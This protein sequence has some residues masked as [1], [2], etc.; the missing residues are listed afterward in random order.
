MTLMPGQAPKR[1]M[2]GITTG[3]SSARRDQLLALA[4]GVV[5]VGASML[6]QGPMRELRTGGATPIVREPETSL[7]SLAVQFPRLT[8]GGFRGL[9]ATVLWIQAENDKND[10]KWVEL[11]TKYDIIGALQPYFVTVYVFHSWNLAYNL[12][13]QWHTNDR[14]YKWVLDGMDYLYRGEGYNPQNPDLL[15]EEG[16]LYFLKLGGS[17]ERI[18]YRKQWRNDLARMHDLFDE[19]GRHKLVDSGS[20]SDDKMLALDHVHNFALRGQ[21]HTQEMEDPSGSG[22]K[23]WGVSITDPV[24][25]K[26]RADGKPADQPM[27]FRYGLSPYYFGYAE[28][29]RCLAA[30]VPSTTGLNVIDA[31][32]AMSLRLWCRDDLYYGQQTMKELFAGESAAELTA[33]GMNEKVLEI[34][35]CYRNVQ[36][37]A[38]RAVDE[39]ERHL[40]VYNGTKGKMNNEPIHR[41]HIRETQSYQAIGKAEGQLFDA[42]VQWQV[43]G[44]KLTPGVVEKLKAALPRY[45]EA[46]GK[47]NEWLDTIYPVTPG[48]EPNPDRADFEKFVIALRGRVKGIEKMLKTPPEERPSLTFL[49]DETVEK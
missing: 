31:W 30:G 49:N 43:D 25:F 15:L 40:L 35:D 48:R 32:P 23:G 39:F 22:R 34:R 4:A 6:L 26:D 44:R 21:F 46:I 13:A 16:H 7:Q 2:A 36:M 42:L 5:L 37:I 27:S 1:R 9:L 19:K 12:S 29:K 18:Y 8:L 45:D 17:F 28:Y 10:R 33:E 47:A 24:L 11:E 41:K 38:P 20:A 14:K 3:Q